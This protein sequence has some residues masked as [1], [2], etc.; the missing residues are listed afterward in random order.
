MDDKKALTLQDMESRTFAQVNDETGLLEVVDVLTGA[1]VSVQESYNKLS[2]DEFTQVETDDGVIYIQRGISINQVLR[3]R[4]K[5]VYDEL[6][7]DVICAR[8]MRG[9]ALHVLCKD[10]RLPS[11]NVIMRWRSK[12]EEFERKLQEAFKLRAEFH[13][14]RILE[15]ADQSPEDLLDLK[16]QQKKIDAHKW[17]ASKDDPHRFGQS[18]E[19]SDAGVATT[20]VIDTGIRDESKP[21]MQLKEVK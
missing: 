15:I 20:I 9:E 18:K 1:I 2:A 4:T 3:K 11:M 17:L 7:A 21:V 12:S 16:D 13:R 6:I 10:E 5:W 14:D 19:K 8:I